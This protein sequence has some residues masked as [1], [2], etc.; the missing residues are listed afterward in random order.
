MQ[1][2]IVVLFMLI[3]PEIF[4]YLSASGFLYR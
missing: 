3:P 1:A 4:S 2:A